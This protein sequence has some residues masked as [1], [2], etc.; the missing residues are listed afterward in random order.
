M[1]YVDRNLLPGERILFRTRKHLIIFF[2]P[3]VWTIFSIYAAIYMQ[4]NSILAALA[5]IPWVIA[6]LLWSMV[7]LQYFFSEFAVTNKRVMMREGLIN[8]HTNE[9]RVSTISQVNVDQNLLGQLLSYGT[10][11]INAFGAFDAYTLIAHPTQF[12]KWVNEQADRALR[13]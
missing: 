9:M 2:I 3:F 11:S 1:S 10:V 6:L 4:Q 8:R 7:G 5:W 12:Q 13:P